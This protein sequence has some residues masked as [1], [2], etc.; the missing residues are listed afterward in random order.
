MFRGVYTVHVYVKSVR[1]YVQKSVC[2][3]IC[4]GECTLYMYMLRR[5]NVYMFRRV[6]TEYV[7]VKKSVR[8]YVQESIH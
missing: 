2:M 3:C 6:F 7:Y 4:S 1:V 8:L 5:V